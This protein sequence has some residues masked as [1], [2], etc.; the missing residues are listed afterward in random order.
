[1]SADH[2]H[3]VEHSA[4]PHD[5]QVKWTRATSEN[6]AERRDGPPQLPSLVLGLLSRCYSYDTLKKLIHK[7]EKPKDDSDQSYRDSEAHKR[8][9]FVG[10]R[11]S[12]ATPTIFSPPFLNRGCATSLLL[13]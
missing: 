13:L 11:T 1:M 5:L 2:A 12:H 10:E 9:S 8:T 4:L 3:D 7:L 6:P